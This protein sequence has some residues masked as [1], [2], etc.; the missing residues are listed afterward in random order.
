MHGSTRSNPSRPP[1]TLPTKFTSAR[2]VSRVRAGKP[3]PFAIWYIAA[4]RPARR[5][6][7]GLSPA[8]FSELAS[9]WP[10]LEGLPT[11]K[12]GVHERWS[13]NGCCHRYVPS[14][15]FQNI[16]LCPQSGDHGRIGNRTPKHGMGAAGEGLVGHAV[17][18]QL[19]TR[20]TDCTSA[21]SLVHL[22]YTPCTAH[23]AQRVGEPFVQWQKSVG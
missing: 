19:R 4:R 7:S 6:S 17:T 10:R 21:P 14:D 3:R 9:M 8:R 13:E 15:A 1:S 11:V 5:V 23:I 20:R 12:D 18:G 2:V 22:H 16:L